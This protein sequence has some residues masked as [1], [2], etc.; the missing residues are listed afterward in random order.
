MVRMTVVWPTPADPES[1]LLGLLSDRLA[2][3]VEQLTA[4]RSLR[5]LGVTYGEQLEL[6]LAVEEAFDVE[7][8]ECELRR[9]LTVS[10][11]LRMLRGAQ[12][13]EQGRGPS[14]REPEPWPV[15]PSEEMP[16]L[17]ELPPSVSVC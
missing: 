2:V 15:P 3:P 7:L 1:E 5:E 12:D 17:S 13:H 10:D 11:W 6:A 14:V 16:R 4:S 8:R 9:A